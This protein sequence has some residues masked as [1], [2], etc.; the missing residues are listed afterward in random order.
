MLR[1]RRVSPEVEPDESEQQRGPAAGRRL[2]DAAVLALWLAIFIGLPAAF[3]VQLLR[4]PG[5]PPV[6]FSDDDLHAIIVRPDDLPPGFVLNHESRS[7]NEDAARYFNDPER[8]RALFDGWQRQGGVGTLMTDQGPPLLRD[9]VQVATAVER[10]PD[11]GHAER[12]FEGR[13]QLFQDWNALPSATR[14]IKA[15]RVGDQSAASRMYVTDE[16]GQELVVYSITMRTGPI[17]ADITTT[18]YKFKDDE[19]RQAIQ[20]ARLVDERVS[21]HLHRAARAFEDEGP[22][23]PAGA[24]VRGVSAALTDLRRGMYLM[25]PA[26]VRETTAQLELL[27]QE[28]EAL[29]ELYGEP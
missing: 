22:R 9:V 23:T 3:A 17:V 5:P 1:P 18:G 19:G 24:L 14:S 6:V 20:L 4:E 11:A 10:Y 27:R 13:G 25:Q 8:V 7:A 16:A 2:K 26:S 29:G 21:A 15:P 28:L 12:R